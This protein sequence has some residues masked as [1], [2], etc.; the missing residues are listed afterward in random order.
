MVWVFLEVSVF[1]SK[2]PKRRGEKKKRMRR[3]EKRDSWWERKTG[4]K[5]LHDLE[6][7]N[8]SERDKKEY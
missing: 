7:S 8:A 1:I 5:V 4:I 2:T 6:G 3:G